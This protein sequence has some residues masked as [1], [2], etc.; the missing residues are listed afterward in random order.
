MVL[1]NP[2]TSCYQ[3]SEADSK[4][5]PLEVHPLNFRPTTKASQYLYV[6]VPT[7]G[8][9]FRS[10]EGHLSPVTSSPISNFDIVSKLLA[11]SIIFGRQLM[12]YYD[13][14]LTTVSRRSVV[15][16]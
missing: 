6:Q 10:D 14:L 11:V 3:Q 9:A 1:K 13:V 16:L 12:N 15:Q 2:Y 7:V 5:V 4:Y 8:T